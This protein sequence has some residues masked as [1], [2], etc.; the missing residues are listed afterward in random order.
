[1]QAS[2]KY[3]LNVGV[4]RKP[5]FIPQTNS[6]VQWSGSLCALQLVERLL[7]PTPPPPTIPS[8]LARHWEK[9]L[10]DPIDFS[11]LIDSPI[12][13]DT[14]FEFKQSGRIINLHSR[15][16]NL[17]KGFKKDK[18]QTILCSL[19]KSPLP[20]TSIEA[21][22]NYLYFKRIKIE[23]TTDLKALSIQLGHVA[24]LCK[25][26]SI[27]ASQVLFDLYALVLPRISLDDLIACLIECWSSTLMQ[28]TKTDS[29][30]NLLASHLRQ[31]PGGTESFSAA[32]EDSDLPAKRVVPLMT[33]F[34]NVSTAFV[35][36]E[37]VDFGSI[38]FGPKKL[39]IHWH[40]TDDPAS[41]LRHPSDYVFGRTGSHMWAIV[42]SEYVWSQWP[43]F[44]R[45]VASG[46][47]E[48]TTR[49]V[50]L[51]KW[52]DQPTI[53]LIVSCLCR[54]EIFKLEVDSAK[55]MVRHAKEYGFVDD[56]GVPTSCFAHLFMNCV[57]SGRFSPTRDHNKLLQLQIYHDLGFDAK[58][59][60][61]MGHVTNKDHPSSLADALDE[62]SLELLTKIR[63]VRL[64]QKQKA[65]PEKK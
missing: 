51:G 29:L 60:D 34:T 8:S 12:I 42:P 21:F 36:E 37:V 38:N 19:E 50:R 32:V 18:S 59:L 53:E 35:I 3:V 4:V 64:K 30:I 27:N 54:G 57:C 55:L 49:I 65:A 6:I 11:S 58:A 13:G 48:S 40:N 24:W 17:N 15:V 28:W 9:R 62:L 31:S 41:L 39:T 26:H 43:W 1:M 7:R 45:L 63:D 47:E 33:L 22:I 56:I 46:M 61:L 2:I 10:P 25:E 20:E 16:L 14:P 52:M 5:I 23:D 44:K